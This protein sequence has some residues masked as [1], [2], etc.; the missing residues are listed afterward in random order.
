MSY[1]QRNTHTGLRRTYRYNAK[2][3]GYCVETHKLRFTAMRIRNEPTSIKHGT[4]TKKYLH[5]AAEFQRTKILALH[6]VK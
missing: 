4:E 1:S 5:L 3:N 6:H 2:N